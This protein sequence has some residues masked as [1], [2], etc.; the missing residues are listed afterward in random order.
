MRMSAALSRHP[1]ES[2]D[3]AAQVCIRVEDRGPGIP[4]AELPLLFQQ[5]GR[6]QRDL[7]GKVRGSGLGLYISRQ[8]V[9]AMHGQIWVEGSAKPG[10]AISFCFTLPSSPP[11]PPSHR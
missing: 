11:P 3:A 2:A 4:P 9:E 1:S 5:F 7:A 10:E 8:L 6:L